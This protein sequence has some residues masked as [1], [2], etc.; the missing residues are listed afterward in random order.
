VRS[1]VNMYWGAQGPEMTPGEAQ[2]E[3]LVG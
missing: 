3:L 2:Q 1:E